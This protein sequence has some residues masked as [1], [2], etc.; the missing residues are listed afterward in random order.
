MAGDRFGFV[1][2]LGEARRDPVRQ[3]P[4]V[5]PPVDGG[6]GIG[7][8]GGALRVAHGPAHQRLRLRVVGL[9]LQR[10]REVP[11]CVGLA[12]G[13]EE[14][15]CEVQAQRQVVRAGVDGGGEARDQG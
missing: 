9:L 2:G 3:F 5:G 7:R 14:Q 8:P 12:A 6:G 10:D 11:D 13:V 1:A 15:G 4:L